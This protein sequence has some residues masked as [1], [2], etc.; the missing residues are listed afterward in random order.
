MQIRM[1]REIHI[2][3]AIR[4]EID[5]QLVL[6]EVLYC[7]SIDDYFVIGSHVTQRPSN[8]DTLVG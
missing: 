4:I 6:G 7:Q 3:S 2:G 5:D 8:S 1:N